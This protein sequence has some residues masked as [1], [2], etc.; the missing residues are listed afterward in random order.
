VP[1]TLANVGFDGQWVTPYQIISH[2]LDGPVL[3]AYNWLDASSVEANR[4]VL[5]EYGYLPTMPFNKVLELALEI[6]GLRR[7]HIY[8]TQAFHLLPNTL[9]SN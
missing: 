3:V 6:S 5:K 4:E 1:C 2:A 7:E 8:V 9:C